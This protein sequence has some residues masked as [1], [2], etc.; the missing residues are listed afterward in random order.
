MLNFINKRNNREAYIKILNQQKKIF[1]E[2]QKQLFEEKQKQ[3]QIFEEEQKYNKINI[4]FILKD[5]YNSI[6]PLNLY[7]CWHTLDLPP[8]MS[9]NY[10]L[11]LK[12]NPEF[13]HF[14][15]DENMCRQFL[16]ENFDNSVIESYDKLIPCAFKTD[17]WRYC[18]L[19]INGGIYIDIKYECTNGFKFIALTEEEYFVRDYNINNI[20][21][22]LIVCKRGNQILLEAIKQIVENVKN[23]FYGN[24]P[25]DITGPGLLSNY[26]TETEKNNLELYHSYTVTN[27][28]NEYYIVYN[29]N[30]ILRFY[31]NYREE[32]LKN[33][34]LEHYSILWQKKQIYIYIL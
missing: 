7:T 33:Q 34:K 4:N 17:L 30:I 8:L 27:K 26:F 31:N 18:V 12:N 29:N 19:Y 11:L 21:N 14:I 22:A 5:H 23:N 25:L 3:Q 24:D 32:Q 10:K 20:Y 15:Y 16:I 1:E 2:K 6:I 9:E 13:N 28:I